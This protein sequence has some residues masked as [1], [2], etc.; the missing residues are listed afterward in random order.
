MTIEDSILDTLYA[1]ASPQ[2]PYLKRYFMGI[3]EDIEKY[4]ANEEND[5]LSNDKEDLMY[6]SHFFRIAFN[7][8]G[9]VIIPP[10][11]PQETNDFFEYIEKNYTKQSAKIGENQ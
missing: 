2:D 8:Q 5:L 1:I 9:E 4:L 10:P 7:G 3:E 11:A 6:L